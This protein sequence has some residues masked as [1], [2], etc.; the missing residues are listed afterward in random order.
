MNDMPSK[1]LFSYPKHET[2]GF[3]MDWS[4]IKQGLLATGDCAGNIHI[5]RPGSDGG[6]NNS[7]VTPTYE[8]NPNFLHNNNDMS[9]SVE[10]LQWSPSEATVLASAECGGYVRIFDTRAP[11]KAMLCHQIHSASGADVNV[12]SWN[13]LVNNLLATGGDDG[14]LS[15][16][17]LRHFSGNSNDIQPLARFTPHKTPITSVEWHPTDESMLAASDDVAAYIYDLSVEED[18][19]AVA[20][21]QQQD[22]PPQLLFVHSG[23]EQFKELH[24]HPQVSSCLMTTALSGFS[25]FIPSN[26]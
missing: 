25:V 9:P 23:S 8:A 26:L 5:W 2:E 16:W 7:S 4:P 24:W 17:D 1:P 20:A 21:A 22:V 19:T 15:V 13:K 12:L 18:D 3:A 11:H 14:C 10:D 6:Y